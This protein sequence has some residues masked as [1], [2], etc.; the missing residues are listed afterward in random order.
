MTRYIAPSTPAVIGYSTK[1]PPAAPARWS[2]STRATE[3]AAA[4]APTA[5]LADTE[6]AED[7]AQQVFS[8]ELARDLAQRV[9][10]QPQLLGGQLHSFL[11]LEQCERF[12]GMP[13]GKVQRFQVA[14]AR[15][16]GAALAGPVAGE[17]LEALAQQL[18]P[19]AGEGRE[20]NYAA[21]GIG[22]VLARRE[23]EQVDLVADFQH[24][25]FS[26]QFRQA[27]RLARGR[28]GHEQHQ[29]GVLHRV[30]RAAD[31]F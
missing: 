18:Q 6:L 5:L 30:A 17:S 3:L 23:A 22:R 7:P 14:A 16:V 4:P 9:V 13:A 29:V 21:P 25:N 10:R 26:G 20:V 11:R 1:S 27:A 2:R 24:G 12:P 19:R 8:G 28:I 31:A 15:R